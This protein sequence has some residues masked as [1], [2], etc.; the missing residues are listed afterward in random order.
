MRV[1]DDEALTWPEALSGT[2]RY[3]HELG[4]RPLA[5][6]AV[7]LTG[8]G[9]VAA[10][11]TGSSG[12]WVL[13]ATLVVLLVLTVPSLLRASSGPVQVNIDGSLTG[14]FFTPRAIVLAGV[15]LL[16]S[17]QQAA[18]MTALG[19]SFCT[20]VGELPTR[21]LLAKAFPYAANVSAPSR[22]QNWPTIW[23]STVFFANVLVLGSVLAAA[24]QPGLGPTALA[25]NLAAAALLCWVA[26]DA[27]LRTRARQRFD[28]ELPSV[29]ADLNPK[30]VLH[31][32]APAGTAYQVR[33][34]LPLLERS[35]IPFYVMLRD[36]RCFRD[37]VAATSAPIVVCPSLELLE[38]ALVPSLRAALYVN[39][40][41]SN[42]H[43]IRY[44][45][46]TH[47]QLNHGDSD[48][49]PSHNPVFRL[50]DRNFVAG[51][52]AI[53]RFV[54]NGIV[55][56]K[57]YF[58][59]VGRPQ[60]ADLTLARPDD[61]ATRPSDRT[62]LYAPTWLGFHSDSRYSS[63]GDGPA[64]VSA[65][66]K[67]HCTVIFRPHP[68]SLR[69]PAFRESINAIIDLLEAD[70]AVSGCQHIFGPAADTERT[71]V[72]CMNEADALIGDVSSV[73]GD[74]LFSGKPYAIVSTTQSADAFEE[75]FPIAVGGY[76]VELQDLAKTLE[77][78]LA[79]FL[80]NDPKQSERA[81]IRRYY[82]GDFPD[83]DYAEPF[84][85]ALRD[86]VV[87]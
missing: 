54:A 22:L 45:H 30:F 27:A 76:V 85:G 69:T 44:S 19:L 16:S 43:L 20:L 71:L 21:V 78:A 80:T 60:V 49:A 48:K 25:L 63:L 1:V 46:L 28:G 40:A 36:E 86:L 11:P 84:L 51:Q 26:V 68:Y 64:I 77:L 14:A 5:L 8:V 73:V 70:A 35:G 83:G 79:A 10:S 87:Q 56:P 52:A 3:V 57:D 66:L 29:L 53:D 42:A 37:V 61:D 39:T 12:P 7:G 65:L 75:A 4:L 31:W 72:Q 24:L 34:W 82:L 15:L 33:M 23:P 58:T 67:R 9:L 2:M 18:T 59:I 6:S 38:S 81:K 62:V 55:M 13:S 47:V 74:F 17:S 32:D 41:T 50:Y